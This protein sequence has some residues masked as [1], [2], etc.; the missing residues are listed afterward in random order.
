[1]FVVLFDI[2]THEALSLH[3]NVL[4]Q[5]M[6]VLR[7]HLVLQFF[8]LLQDVTAHGLTLCLPVGLSTL[9][10]QDMNIEVSKLWER[11]VQVG[12]SVGVVVEQVGTCPVKHRHEVIADG[13]NTLK[14]E[15]SQTFLISLYL[16][17][18]VGTGILDA[19]YHRQRL[20]H[21][22][23]HSVTFDV[24]LQVADLLAG[25]HLTIRY[26]VQG[27]NN[28]FHTNFFQHG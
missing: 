9:A 24:L 2:S 6:I 27:R 28:A 10:L 14:R 16:L 11:E 1:M 7:S 12:T 21:T 3:D 4:H 23:S 13:M 15:V 26:I 8:H 18:S 19:L 22:P 25:P 5:L 17:I 20:Y